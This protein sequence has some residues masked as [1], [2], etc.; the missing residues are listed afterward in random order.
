[1]REKEYEVLR[2]LLE[3]LHLFAAVKSCSTVF[4]FSLDATGARE[5]LT[6]E[7]RRKE[8]SPSADGD[9][10]Y[11]PLTALAFCKRRDENF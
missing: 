4:H 7:K 10:G 2:T 9:K 3:R 5:K 8:I 11:A 6:K 1:M